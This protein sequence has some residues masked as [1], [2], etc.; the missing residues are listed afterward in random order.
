M[1]LMNFVF[2]PLVVQASGPG[3]ESRIKFWNALPVALG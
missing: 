2:H 1:K 3:Y